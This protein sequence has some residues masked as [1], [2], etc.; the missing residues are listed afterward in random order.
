MLKIAINDAMSQIDKATE[1]IMGN[2]SQ[3]GGLF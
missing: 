3:L 2:L 1:K